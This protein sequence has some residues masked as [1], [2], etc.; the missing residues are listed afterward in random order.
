MADAAGPVRRY[1]AKTM[2][3]SALLGRQTFLAGGSLKFAV[4]VLSARRVRGSIA[5]RL[6]VASV[7]ASGAR[8]RR[9]TDACS[10]WCDPKAG[11]DIE[12]HRA[13]QARAIPDFPAFP[14][15]IGRRPR[16]NEPLCV[17]EES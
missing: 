7:S 3:S 8:H 11:A 9:G 17:G 15:L 13:E 16:R 2:H 1:Y 5:Q 10:A 14:G 4:T 12:R 6:L